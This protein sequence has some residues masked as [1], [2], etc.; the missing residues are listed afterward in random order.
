MKIA[1][2]QMRYF[3]IDPKDIVWIKAILESYEGMVVVR[4]VDIK[5]PVIELLI[6]PDFAHTLGPVIEEIASQV[7]MDEIPGSETWAPLQP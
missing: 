2:T 3:I 5:Q 4:T 6:A 1:E 7:K